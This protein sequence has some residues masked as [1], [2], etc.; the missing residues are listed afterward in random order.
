MNEASNLRGNSVGK[1]LVLKTVIVIQNAAQSIYAYF[2]FH[3]TILE[4]I[5]HS[6]FEI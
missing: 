3:H 6:K 4:R 1:Q 2:P 5:L